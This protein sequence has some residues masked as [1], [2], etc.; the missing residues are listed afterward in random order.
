MLNPAL[1]DLPDTLLALAGQFP[2]DFVWGVATSAYQIE[3]AASEAGKGRSIWDSFCQLPGVIADGSNGDLACDHYHRW[4]EDLDLV[5]SLGVNAYRFS[6]SWPRV[7]PNGSG[8]WNNKG[9]DFYERVVDGLL[10]RG[11]RPMSRSTIGT[12]RKSC[13][14]AADGPTARRCTGLLSMRGALLRA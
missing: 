8:A 12:C 1:V 3:G 11:S 2:P 13:R 10:E 5:A 14:P 9:V 4:S 6:V 7:R